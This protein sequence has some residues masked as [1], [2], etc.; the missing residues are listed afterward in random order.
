MIGVRVLSVLLVAAVPV[1][2]HTAP[3]RAHRAVDWTRTVA[4]TPEGGIRIGNP[5]A[6]VTLVEY[7]SYTCPHCG[8][9]SREASAAIRDRYVRTGRISFEFRV[10]LRDR[11]DVVAAI[12]ARCG[13]PA[14]AP[15]LTAAI[16]AGQPDWE[17]KAIDWDGAHPGDFAAAEG[18]Q[19]MTALADAAGLS[20]IAATQKLSDAQLTACY[21][22]K[23][24]LATLSRT[25]DD[26]WNV[27]KIGGTPAFYLNGVKLDGV[28]GWTALEPRIQAALK[29]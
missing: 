18:P 29:G 8:A 19:Q 23:T 11:I 13:G 15:A 2:T 27:R 12:T 28:Y 3:R 6:K 24:I 9:F 17:Q 26:A 22:D 21:G 14:R 5:Q 4:A 7:G 20:A 25:A 10:A 16:F 1:A